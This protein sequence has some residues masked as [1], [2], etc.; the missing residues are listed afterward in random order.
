MFVTANGKLEQI[1]GQYLN[2]RPPPT[3]ETPWA[4]TANNNPIA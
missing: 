2:S 1:D 3:L 4:S